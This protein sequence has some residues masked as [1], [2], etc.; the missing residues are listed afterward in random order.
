MEVVM[1]AVEGARTFAVAGAAYDSFMGRYSSPLARRF[2]EAV[3]V[4]HGQRAVDVGCG[5]GALTGVLVELLGAEAVAACDPSPGFVADCAARHPGVAVRHGRAEAM[6]FD[7]GEFDHALAQLVLHFVSEPD[8]AARELARVVRPGGKVA[9]NVWDFA[10]GMEMLRAFWDAA[11][12]LDPDA[13]DEATT[14]RFGGPGEIAALFD[15]V[16]LD[17][18]A[19]STLQVSSTYA[20]FG[21]LWAGFEAGIGPAGA[22]CIGLAAPAREALR[23]TLF[24]RIGAPVGSFTLR[25]V[26]R[27]V[28]ATVTAQ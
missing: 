23:S 28:V 11:T 10:D 21:E 8:V 24:E 7:D 17:D 25:A 20:D 16:G 2:A 12:S 19:E 18:I 9:A 4:Q 22:Y 5:P 14:L 6:P 26:A 1:E 13:P 27:C 3:E 15:S